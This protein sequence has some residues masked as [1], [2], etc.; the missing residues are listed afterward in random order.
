MRS[1]GAAGRL[2]EMVD[3]FDELR[4]RR[5]G[6]DVEDKDLAALETGEPELAAIVS[7]SAVMRFVPSFDRNAVEDFAVGR[8]AGFRIDG[9]EFVVAVA[10][11]FNAE[12]PDVDEFFL[13]VDAGEVRRRAG[14][15]G[16]SRR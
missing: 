10:E 3:R 16:A 9:D 6:V 2:C 7:K 13:S 4:F 11:T 8:R 15:I 14:F 5:I 12:S 1:D